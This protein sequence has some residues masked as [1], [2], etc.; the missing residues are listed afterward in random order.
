MIGV[1]YCDDTLDE[2]LGEINDLYA[3][4]F[5]TYTSAVA[6]GDSSAGQNRTFPTVEYT[7]SQTKDKCDVTTTGDLH[8][9]DAPTCASGVDG[10]ADSNGYS[11]KVVA[12]VGDKDSY[13]PYSIGNDAAINL[14]NAMELVFGDKPSVGAVCIYAEEARKPA[15]ERK[16]DF[17]PGY[18][19]LDSP[20]ETDPWGYEVSA[21]SHCS[22][23]LRTCFCC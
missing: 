21:R 14:D 20:F 22:F 5:L 1:R 6:L 4:I 18:C 2:C 12:I 3:K 8:G 19:C 17:L 13:S 23:S 16:E 15:D 9:F 7:C 10:S 11:S